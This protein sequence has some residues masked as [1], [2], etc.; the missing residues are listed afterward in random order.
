MFKPNPDSMRMEPT[1]E[2]VLSVCRMVAQQSMTTEELRKTLF[3]PFVT[4]D[5]ARGSGHGSGLG[6]SIT[7]R[8]LKLHG[9]SI[10]LNEA[11]EAPLK[12]EFLLIF[13]L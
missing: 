13:P 1:P 7:E 11:P 10:R 2:R 4:G 12:T 9:G 6:L 8:I 3:L 5:A